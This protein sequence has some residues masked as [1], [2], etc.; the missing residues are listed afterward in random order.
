ML[1]FVLDVDVQRGEAQC[2]RAAGYAVGADIGFPKAATPPRPSPHAH[3]RFLPYWGRWEGDDKWGAY[4]IMEAV[5]A[6]AGT[7]TFRVGFSAPPDDHPSVPRTWVRYLTLSP[8]EA[9]RGLVAHYADGT[10]QWAAQLTS[11]LE[12]QLIIRSANERG[13]RFAYQVLLRRPAG[14]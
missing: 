11:A 5:H 13:G 6:G 8:D 9:G 4:F 14:E 7:I 10:G 2:S 1:D 12:L 3:A